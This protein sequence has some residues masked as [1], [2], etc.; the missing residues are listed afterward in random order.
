M[1]PHTQITPH[2]D[3]F[4][5][6]EQFFALCNNNLLRWKQSPRGNLRALVG[7]APDK[8]DDGSSFKWM[9]REIK[10]TLTHTHAAY[11]DRWVGAL[12]EVGRG[13]LLNGGRLEDGSGWA[14]GGP[15]RR[16]VVLKDFLG[17]SRAWCLECR[18]TELHAPLYHLAY[19]H[20]ILSDFS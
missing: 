15:I 11:L 8:K 18:Y 1:S 13:W 20:A 12:G 17:A 19:R 14:G 3:F 10:N 5:T 9:K 6:E 2:F 4:C 16:R 7:S